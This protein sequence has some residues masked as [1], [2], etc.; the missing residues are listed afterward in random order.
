MAKTFTRTPETMKSAH[1]AL[2]QMQSLQEHG[3]NREE[4]DTAQSYLVGHLA[5]EFETSDNVASKVLD[6]I[7]DGLP[8]DYWNSLSGE[9]PS[10]NHDGR[11]TP[12]P[13]TIWTRITT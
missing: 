7:Q 13:S 8:L 11:S 1:I 10:F 5:L 9:G 4:L 6:L 2:E 3:I 12:P